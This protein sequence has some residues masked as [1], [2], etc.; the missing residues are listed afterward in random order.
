MNNDKKEKSETYS[1]DDWGENDL[2]LEDKGD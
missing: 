1:D 2:E